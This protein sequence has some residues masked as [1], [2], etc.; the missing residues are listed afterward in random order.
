MRNGQGW[1]RKTCIKGPLLTPVFRLAVV[2][3]AGGKNVG[4][5]RKMY[6]MFWETAFPPSPHSLYIKRTRKR[7]KNKKQAWEKNTSSNAAH[8]SYKSSPLDSLSPFPM[9]RGLLLTYCKLPFKRQ[10][11]KAS[12]RRTE[13]TAARKH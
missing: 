10:K 2:S 9:C 12:S 6:H 11:R 1:G 5:S 7:K 3:W 4:A 13:N 8:N